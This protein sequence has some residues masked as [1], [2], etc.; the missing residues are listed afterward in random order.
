MS[1]PLNKLNMK[2]SW[3][4]LQNCWEAML[5]LMCAPGFTFAEVAIGSELWIR[6]AVEDSRKIELEIVYLY[7]VLDNFP[8]ITRSFTLHIKPLGEFMRLHILM[9]TGTWVCHIS[10]QL[11]KTCSCGNAGGTTN[12]R[13]ARAS[14]WCQVV[15]VSLSGFVLDKFG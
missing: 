7:K 3:K 12:K 11:G 4:L 1:I 14:A 8:K 10:G 6:S 5:W 15:L 2:G 13:S 9:I